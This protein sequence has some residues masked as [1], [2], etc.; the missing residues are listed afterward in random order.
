[1]LAGLLAANVNLS[2]GEDLEVPPRI[3]AELLGK[4]V[5]YDR[6]LLERAG[7]KVV[8]AIVTKTSDADSTWATAQMEGALKRLDLI[9]G[10]PHEEIV[11]PWAGASSLAELCSKRRV[12]ILY[13]TPGLGGDIK[14]VAAALEGKS[15]LT[16]GSVTSYVGKGA[17]LGF[18]L[19]SGRTKLVINLAQGKKQSVQFRAEVLKLMRIVQ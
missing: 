6:N 2:W 16:V 18:E 14:A 13:L 9:G 19:V 17:V 7:P 15:V 11:V 5:P 10:L 3:Q 4:V 12:S 1:V 8:I